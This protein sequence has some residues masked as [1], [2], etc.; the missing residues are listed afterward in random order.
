MTS[1]NRHRNWIM[2]N[3]YKVL[4]IFIT[5]LLS[6]CSG[7]SS[8][9]TNDISSDIKRFSG[10]V[11]NSSVQGINVGAIQ[12]GKQGQFAKDENNNTKV[13]TNTSD[14]RGKFGFSISSDDVGP[15]VLSVIAPDSENGNIP[16][17][18]SCQWVDGCEVNEGIVSFGEFFPLAANKRWSAAV[19]GISN[20]QFIVINPITELAKAFGYSEY[21][22][23]NTESTTKDGTIPAA[24][25]YSNYGIVKGNTQTASVFGINDILSTEPVDLTILHTLNLSDST[26]IEQSIRYGALLAAWQVMELEY[27]AN[28]VIGGTNFIVGVV[29]QFLANQGQFYQ[30]PAEDANVFSLKEWYV[31]AL[32]NLKDVRSYHKGLGRSLPGEINLVI[33]S[34]ETEIGSL[35]DGALTAA[36]PTIPDYYLD[37]YADA[38]EKTKAMVNYLTN[39][40]DNFATQEYRDSIKKS[41]DLV[42]AE[43]RRLSPKLDSIFRH[44]LS[45]QQYYLTCSHGTCD[46][47]S[48]WHGNG[49]IFT[50]S[51]KTLKIL[52]P[53]GTE[54]EVSQGLVFDERAPEG[55]DETNVHD[56]FLVGAFEFE[57]L[58]LEFTDTASEEASVISSSLRFSYAKALSQMPLPPEILV[59]GLGVTV[60]EDLMPDYI[61]L[62]MPNFRLYDSSVVGSSEELK[63]LGSLTSLM[64]ANT[65]TGDFIKP[66]L[67]K[68]GKRYNLASVKGSFKIVGPDQDMDEEE[69]SLRDNALI[70][71]EANASESFAAGENYTAYFPDTQYPTFKSFFKPREGFEVGQTSPFDLVVSRRGTVNFPKLDSVGNQVGT[72]EIQAEYIELDYTIGGLERY[73]VYPKLEGEDEYWGFVCTAQPEDKAD[74]IAAG[75]GF[76]KTEQDS[77]GNEYQRSLLTCPFRAKYSGDATPDDLVNQVYALNK[78]LF[79][80][81]EYNGYGAY[82]INYALTDDNELEVFPLEETSYAG[83]L[84]ESVILGIDSLRLQFKPNLVGDSGTEYLPESLL[85]VSLIWRTKDVIDV[86]AL[87]AFDTERVIN[88]PNGSGLPFLSVGTDSESY[89]VAY[90]TNEDGSESGEYVMAW[91][92]VRF[93]EGPPTALG[94]P[95][96]QVLQRTDVEDLKEGVFAG[97]GSNVSYTPESSITD[98]KCGFFSRGEEPEVGEE[99]DVIAYFTF[100]GLVT[101][102]LREERDGV[103]VIRYIDGSFQ[104]LGD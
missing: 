67:E 64:V 80:L 54:L 9:V 97:I 18:E 35:V 7:N 41:S 14:E 22:N 71:I 104:I 45:I 36:I 21:I 1:I 60:D 52:N 81:R 61:E 92:G 96:P 57:G 10:V 66:D 53:V 39:L 2:G 68:L 33:S 78:G 86:N 27:D 103:Y 88:N 77:E 51:T 102:S 58:R 55:S 65:D 83:T 11:N 40:K 69:A 84:E 30:A 29:A 32:K 4:S 99:C 48:D 13:L 8:N 94:A 50:A 75:Q 6:G 46:T 16:A 25:Y 37:D 38:S 24:N 31:N 73:V 47:T 44:L 15:Y 56:L 42:T 26:A 62:L 49:N 76:T 17:V 91:A 72:E 98:E 79:N 74:L 20:G 85:D 63:L 70:F 5:A 28:K 23:N 43:I 90:R 100:R 87:L 95:G 89:S 34:F 59:G 82:R 93:V 19:E 101:G 12:I 3:K